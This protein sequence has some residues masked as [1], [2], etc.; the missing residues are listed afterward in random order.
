MSPI[1]DFLHNRTRWKAKAQVLL[2]VFFMLLSASAPGQNL[3]RNGD[4]EA[5][6]ST[7]D[8]V[9]QFSAASIPSTNAYGGP[10]D[11]AIADRSNFS[12][13]TKNCSPRNNFEGSK[14]ATALGF[15]GEC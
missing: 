2:P 5:P 13:D 11:F 10:G 3:L 8:W 12:V 6:L 7:N 15:A 1:R 4:F 14:V 9:I